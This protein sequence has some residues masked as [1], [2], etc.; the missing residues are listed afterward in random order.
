MS[1]GFWKSVTAPLPSNLSSAL[2]VCVGLT[3]MA[4]SGVFLGRT[5]QLQADLAAAEE[6]RPAPPAPA[7]FTK[8]TYA[9][10]FEDL[11]VAD[12]FKYLDIKE[13]RY[14]DI[15]AWEPV[16]DSNTYL[17]YT[18][19][20]RGVLVEPNDFYVQKIRAT[21]PGDKVLPVGVGITDQEEA[22]YFMVENVPGH[23]TFSPEVAEKNRGEGRKV[24]AVKKRLVNI[25]AVIAEN[26]KEP[27]NFISIDVEGL[28]FDILKTLD[29]DK[30]RPAVI[31]AETLVVN[32]KGV[33]Y[34]IEEFLRSKNYSV[35]GATFVNTIFVANE[36]LVEKK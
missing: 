17:F 33:D 18:Q 13:I 11:I 9:Q 15:G 34:R 22:D 24:T 30:Y 25:N 12:I 1:D 6:N 35:R 10:Q 20:H 27:P 26:F 8:T 14:L 2:F 16:Q 36:L 19:G 23:N 28:D 4:L 29:F 5:H 32:T 7:P 21:R 3:A 31:C